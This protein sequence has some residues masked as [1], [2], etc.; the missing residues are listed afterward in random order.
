M[1]SSGHIF[2]SLGDEYAI[3]GRVVEQNPVIDTRHIELEEVFE[4][5]SVAAV[6]DVSGH[7]VAAGFDALGDAHLGHFGRFEPE[8][9]E[10]AAVAH[11]LGFDDEGAVGAG[12]EGRLNG[13][14]GTLCQQFVNP[15]DQKAA[16]LD[17]DALGVE[18]G[19][20]A[21]DFVGV[22]ELLAA[23]NLGQHRVGGGGFACAVAA[24]DD[25]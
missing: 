23:E 15:F 17:G 11:L 12:G 16:S 8:V 14:S 25:V 10:A 1:N 18:R 24:G 13:E 20:A 9:E 4:A 22:D 2:A 21:C 6:N 7:A 19:E 5:K 3:E